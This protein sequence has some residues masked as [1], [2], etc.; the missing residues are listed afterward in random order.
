MFGCCEEGSDKFWHT[1]GN[2]EQKKSSSSEVTK[3][4][5]IS[6]EDQVKSNSSVRDLEFQR[7][8]YF[9]IE[10]QNDFRIDGYW[11]FLTQTTDLGQKKLEI[12]SM[13]FLLFIFY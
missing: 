9:L 5:I 1:E 12:N 3:L 6:V 11:H 4:N 10:W 13:F 8:I 2:E 7:A